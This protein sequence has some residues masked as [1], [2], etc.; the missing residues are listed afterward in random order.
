LPKQDL[1]DLARSAEVEG[2]TSL[3]KQDL[4]KRLG[5]KGVLLEALPK[6][7]LLTAGEHLGLE[8]RQAMTKRELVD[9]LHS[10]PAR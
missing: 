7:S 9:M 10:P 3:T 8:V 5:A 4:V 1:V 2:G 6:R